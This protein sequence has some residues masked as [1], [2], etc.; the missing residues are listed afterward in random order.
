MA[1]TVFCHQ[2][3]ELSIQVKK[4]V[5]R[6]I[7]SNCVSVKK[8][9]LNIIFLKFHNFSNLHFYVD[10]KIYLTQKIHL[11]LIHLYLSFLNEYSINMIIFFLY[12]DYIDSNRTSF[13]DPSMGSI[14][15]QIIFYLKTYLIRKCFFK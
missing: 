10:N 12:Q 2:W 13:P 8:L 9:I 1:L 5:R 4:E 7:E 11:R 14:L 6:G 3:D 15:F